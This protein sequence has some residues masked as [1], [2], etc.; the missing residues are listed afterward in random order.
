[1]HLT[2]ALPDPLF[3]HFQEYNKYVC[4][5]GKEYPK[6]KSKLCDEEVVVALRTYLESDDYSQKAGSIY[7]AYVSL[8][9]PVT[10]P[11]LIEFRVTQHELHQETRYA[12]WW[13]CCCHQALQSAVHDQEYRFWD[14]DE[15][16]PLY[17]QDDD[18][19]SLRRWEKTPNGWEPTNVGW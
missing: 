9:R 4:I 6:L 14:Y 17:E 19:F 1:M 2:M 8:P 3:E 12:S 13:A 7:K 15:M 11:E 18:D 5:F 10:V 16:V